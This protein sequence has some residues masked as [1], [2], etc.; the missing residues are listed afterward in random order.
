MWAHKWC[1]RFT[2][3]G[4]TNF[5][6][7]FCLPTT[8]TT[9]EHFKDYALES[10]IDTSLCH[11]RASVDLRAIAE[12]AAQEE[13]NEDEHD[14]AA[15]ARIALQAERDKIESLAL[16]STPLIVATADTVLGL[17]S[18]AR[19][20]VYSLP[21][22][23]CSAIV[24]DEIHAFDDQL[25]G[26]L[27]VFLK[28]LPHLPVL[29]MTASLPTER[30]HAIAQVRP[31][32]FVV[33]GPEEF[34]T[35]RRYL[36]ND[37][38]TDEEIWNAVDAC[39][40]AHGKVLWVRNRVEWANQTFA[41]CRKR[42]PDLYV[43]LYH[44]RFRYKDR[45]LRHRRVIDSFKT[46][47][48]GALLVATQVAEMS[49]DL[50]ADLLITDLAPIPSLIQRLGR[51]NRHSVPER[52]QP[53]K[54]AFVRPLPQGQAHVELPYEKVELDKA[55]RWLR[56]LVE[57]GQALHQRDLADAFTACGDPK[58]YDL[59]TAEE[60][61]VFFSGLWR[62]RPGPTRGDGYTVSVLL[63]ADIYA[64]AELDAHGE[65][66]RDWIRQHEVA[67]PFKEAVLKWQRVS[68]VRVAPG[69]AVAYDYNE[70]THEGTGAQWK[71]N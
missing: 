6:L 12:T 24:F 19:R 17:M 37:S 35:L 48:K 32:L 36:V 50:S 58:E 68:M 9:T 63:E 57:R 70:A 22:I 43:D 67:I 33:H 38:A 41:E 20:A 26:H 56:E 23:M 29:L 42:Y 21:A 65:P 39:I 7:F 45:S 15:A 52:P 13:A 5:R 59:T 44:S 8:G 2:K 64:C 10:G 4:R 1:Q 69:D 16:W 14:T 47:G 40:T 25:F 66:T 54:P 55:Q 28:N 18:N 30:R 34:E 60:C 53:P 31:D 49:L 3:K 27:L 62:T 61:A 11:A 71:K 46:P 51:L